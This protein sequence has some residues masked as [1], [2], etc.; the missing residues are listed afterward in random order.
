MKQTLEGW[1]TATII[2]WSAALVFIALIAL[3]A[4][5]FQH[6]ADDLKATQHSL[7]Q[8]QKDQKACQEAAGY[9]ALSGSAQAQETARW[10]DAVSAGDYANVLDFSTAKSYIKLAKDTGCS[11]AQGDE[12]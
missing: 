1:R 12:S 3:L 9:L 5:N 4:I 11:T 10:L 6:K 7:K 2:A 8:A